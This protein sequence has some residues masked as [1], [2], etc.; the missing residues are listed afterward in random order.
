MLICS[1]WTTR[2]V[3]SLAFSLKRFKLVTWRDTK[4][5]KNSGPINLLHLSK[6]RTFNIYPTTNTFTLKERFRIFALKAFYRHALIITYV[7]NNF[8]RY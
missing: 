6:R 5:I 1:F 8:K 2:T 4:V 3:W 7:V